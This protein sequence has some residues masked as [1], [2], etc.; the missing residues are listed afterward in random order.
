MS[1]STGRWVVVLSGG[2]GERMRD[3]V[4]NWL[5]HHKP[6][7]YC[8]FDGSRSTLEQAWRRAAQLAPAE[9]ILTVIGPGHRAHIGSLDTPPGGLL[10]QPLGLDTG[11]GVFFPLSHVMAKDPEATVALLPSDHFITPDGALLKYIEAAY[12][13]AAEFPERIVLLAAVPDGPNP[14][15]GWIEPDSEAADPAPARRIR[16]F[17]EKPDEKEALSFYRQ[18]LLWN[19]MVTVAK[20][21]TLWSLGKEY[22]PELMPKFELFKAAVGTAHEARVLKWIYTQLSPVN[23]STRLLQ[24]AAGRSMVI[25]MTGVEWSDW[26]RPDRV[27]ESLRR[28]QIR[29]AFPPSYA[30]L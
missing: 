18:G 1:S 20:A 14:D 10:E 23:F 4:Q 24:A 8:R 22:L 21:K 16:R 27:Y 13:A 9:R 2:E 15:Y 3:F 11:P 5:G 19:T 12:A 30:S 25:T 28:H 7:Q 26:G 29:P 6:K 17:R